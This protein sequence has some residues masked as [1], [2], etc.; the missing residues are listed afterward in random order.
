[1]FGSMVGQIRK[2]TGVSI[3]LARKMQRWFLIAGQFTVYLLTLLHEHLIW[4]DSKECRGSWKKQREQQCCL[5][6]GCRWKSFQKCCERVMVCQTFSKVVCGHSIK[7]TAKE[8]RCYLVSL[9][10]QLLCFAFLLCWGGK[11]LGQCPKKPTLQLYAEPF[12]PPCSSCCN[13]RTFLE[14][15]SI[16]DTADLSQRPIYSQLLTVRK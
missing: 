1:M 2:M 12:S 15:D 11:W 16:T 13:R 7:S 5:L 8:N 14:M 6:F 9:S 3:K 4:Q 10:G